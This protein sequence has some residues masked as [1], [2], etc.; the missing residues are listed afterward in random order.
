MFF[1]KLWYNFYSYDRREGSSIVMRGENKM[2]QS[3]KI[4]VVAILALMIATMSLLVGFSTLNAQLDI[5]GTATVKKVEWKI[6]FSNVN[7]ISSSNEAYASFT[8]PP[9]I[10]QS[11]SNLINFAAT[12]AQPGHNVSFKVDIV[13]SGDIDAKVSEVD[14][15]GITG[16]E[17]YVSWTITGVKEGDVIGAGETI[18]DVTVTL[19]YTFAED[20]TLVAEDINLS[21]LAARINF[22]QAFE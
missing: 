10:N 20:D 12:M 16:Y 18:E 11:N 14:V 5:K 13:N 15:S 2:E 3:R 17:K 19:S 4:Q 6:E 9:A 1:K 8:T 21:N 7:S 22:T